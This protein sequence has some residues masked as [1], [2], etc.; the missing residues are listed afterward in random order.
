MYKFIYIDSGL[1]I[2][3]LLEQDS[4]IGATVTDKIAVYPTTAAAATVFLFLDSI[5]EIT[6]IFNKGK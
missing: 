4:S 5:A 6:F 2:Q 1:R 3:D